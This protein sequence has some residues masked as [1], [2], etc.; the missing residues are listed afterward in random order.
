MLIYLFVLQIKSISLRK[1]S[2]CLKNKVFGLFFCFL[3]AK[4]DRENV[5][6]MLR[7]CRQN[8]G[9]FWGV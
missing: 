9:V 6:N 1:T 3:S 8:V 5:A 4:V 2:N 7:K